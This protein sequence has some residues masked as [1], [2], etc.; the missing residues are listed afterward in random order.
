MRFAVIVSLALALTACKKSEPPASAPQAPAAA[1]GAAAGVRGKV[2]ERIDAS[3]YSYLRLATPGGEVWAAVP[4]TTVATGAEVGLENPMPMDGFESK[5]LNR[6]FDK[7]LF[8]TLSGQAPAGAPAG[9]APAGM[10][11]AGMPPAGMPPTGMPQG[12]AAQH[13]AAAAGPADVGD[14]KVPKA[15][16]ANAK[17]IAEVYGQKAQLKEQKVTVRGKVVKYNSGIMGKNW[18]HLRDGTGTQA[19]GDND[20]TV[21]SSEAA[22]VGDVVIVVGTVRIDKD[23][24]AGYAYPVIIEEATVAKK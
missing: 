23:F 7:I 15:T 3:P 14:V 12:M 18:I 16:G 2:L 10:P 19:K 13:A 5:T 1:P 20:I 11:P 4:Q 9:A 22:A 8:A 24:G 21:T 17:S 6:K